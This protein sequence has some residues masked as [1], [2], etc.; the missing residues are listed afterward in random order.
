M[1]NRQKAV[2]ALSAV[3]PTIKSF[4]NF[5]AKYENIRKTD[6]FVYFAHSAGVIKRRSIRSL[7]EFIE[8]Q[9][10]DI[11]DRII[12]PELTLAYLLE[13]RRTLLGFNQSVSSL[14]CEINKEI[15]NHIPEMPILSKSMFTRLKQGH[16]MTAHK[17]DI[18]RCF[19]FWLGLKRPDLNWNYEKLMRL[20]SQTRN[21]KGTVFVRSVGTQIESE[22]SLS[23][24]VLKKSLKHLTHAISIAERIRR[25]EIA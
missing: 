1:D 18:L 8:Q 11:E 6:C 13:H 2:S 7:E 20:C 4:Q 16:S 14:V 17:E 10:P 19:A 15:Q 9:S 25:D 24:T 12:L 23:L 5:K 22:L 21:D 3:F